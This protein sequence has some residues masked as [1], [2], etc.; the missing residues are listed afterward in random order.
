MKAFLCDCKNSNCELSAV[1][2]WQ[3]MA[4]PFDFLDWKWNLLLRFIFDHAPQSLGINR[5][6][7]GKSSKSNVARK[8]HNDWLRRYL[9]CMSLDECSKSDS[10]HSFAVGHTWVGEHFL[11]R[12]N[13]KV[14]DMNRVTNQSK[15]NRLEGKFTNFNSP[16]DFVRFH[17]IDSSLTDLKHRLQD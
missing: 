16:C 6:N 3:N 12:N 15:A 10:D 4:V 1:V 5:W 7:C 8:A 13:G 17:S 11:V 14:G 2:C 9:L